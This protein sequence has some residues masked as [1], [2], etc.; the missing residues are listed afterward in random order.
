[1]ILGNDHSDFQPFLHRCDDLSRIHKVGSISHQDQKP[2]PEVA[3]NGRR[4]QP[5]FHSPCK[6]NQ[7]PDDQFRPPVASHILCRSPGGA[8]AAAT[9]VSPGCASSLRTRISCPW[10]IASLGTPTTTSCC[11]RRSHSARA[12]P[13]AIPRQSRCEP[14]WQA[15][16]TE[17][18]ARERPRQW[19]APPTERVMRRDVDTDETDFGRLEYGV[20]PVVKSVSRVPTQNYQVG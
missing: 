12:S 10:D 19:E 3:P 1:M 18:R 14:P 6:K 4:S 9:I 15:W 2:R 11:K 20:E 5:E 7:T 17:R 13:T 8:P 16:M